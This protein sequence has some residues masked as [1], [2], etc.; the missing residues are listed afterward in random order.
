[1][2]DDLHGLST[3]EVESIKAKAVEAKALAYCKSCRY[4]VS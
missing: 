4:M 3:E 2:T 1:M